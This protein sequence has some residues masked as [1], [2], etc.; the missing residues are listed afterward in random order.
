MTD[1]NVW[2]VDS[3]DTFIVHGTGDVEAARRA[4]FDHLLD[5]GDHTPDEAADRI[6]RLQPDL[7][8]C[9]G[10]DCNFQV[11]TLQ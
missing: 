10:P 6:Y 1:L 4:V 2:S 3:D 11:V 9:E 5:L 8:R 7:T